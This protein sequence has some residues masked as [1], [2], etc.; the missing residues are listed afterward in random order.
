[1]TSDVLL[2]YLLAMTTATA[3]PSTTWSAFQ[4][5]AKRVADQ[6]AESD[7]LLS[8]RDGPDL[9]IGTAE[10]REDLVASV[11]V[12]ARLL[13]AVIEDPAVLRTL[14]DPAVLP[15]LAF[16][17]SGDREAFAVE[18]VTTVN[19]AVDLGTLL[20]V[21]TLLHEWRNTALVHADPRLAAAMRRDHP[22]DGA[23][24]PRPAG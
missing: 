12:L 13:S 8:R 6:A 20:P 7:I 19:A 16:L 5:D 3:I 17:P 11:E 2:K 24:V 18:F 10:R 21:S 4:R 22:G 14:A 1:L 9:V 15:W 23:L